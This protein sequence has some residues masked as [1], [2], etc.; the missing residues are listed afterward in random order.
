MEQLIALIQA[1]FRNLLSAIKGKQI[2]DGRQT[3]FQVIPIVVPAGTAIGTPIEASVQLDRAYNKITGIAFF[4]IADGGIANDY[5]V[6]ARSQRLTWIDPINV[7]A[8]QADDGVAPDDKYYGTDIPFASGDTFY[9][10]VTPNA[11]PGTNLTAQM[12]LR[13]ENSLTELPK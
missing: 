4:E 6:G 5:N 8:W 12:V 7:N 1:G 9:A 11:I 10:R 13:L 3:R 2:G